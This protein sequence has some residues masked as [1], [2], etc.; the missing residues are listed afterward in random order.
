MAY[1]LGNPMQPMF[2]PPIIDD[3]VSKDAPVRVYDAFVDTLN[4]YELGISLEPSMRGGADEYYPKHLL[5]LLIYGYSYGIRS[6]RK[7]ERACHDNLSFIWLMGGL[8]PDYRTISRF[9]SLHKEAIKK[10]LKQCVRM[11]IKLDLIEGNI[12]F[13]DGSKF[14]ANASI[15]NTRTKEGYEQYIRKI[16]EQIDQ[17]IN[18]SE[19]IDIKERDDR[20]LMKLKEQVHDKAKLLNKMKDALNALNAQD[21]ENINSTDTDSVKAK[22]RQGTHAAYNVQTTVDGKHGLIIHAEA[23]SQSNDYNQLSGQLEKAVENVGKKPEHICADAGYSDVEDEKKIDPSINIIVPSHKQAQEENGR[24]L[25][26]EFDKEHFIYNDQRDEYTCPEGKHLK[27]TDIPEVNKRRY[28]ANGAECRACPH[29]GDPASGKCTKSP[30]GR[31]ITRLADEKF[32][33][34]LEA[35]YKRPENQELY[36]LRKEKV[37]HPYGHMKRN[38]GAGQFMLRGLPKV[39]AE[40]SLLATCFNI[41]HMMTILTIPQLLGKLASS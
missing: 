20:S 5:K 17:M 26:K 37:E 38:L 41:A 25:V 11:C 27:F 36:K 4:F 32:K 14:R 18:E 16:E 1:T 34:Q 24:C 40:T 8:K 15:N 12:F 29:F 7:L 39:N 21:K 22:N 35:N 6:S 30:D 10:V 13:T 31:R 19:Q 9:R 28:Q 3:Y 2:L 33:E 23:V